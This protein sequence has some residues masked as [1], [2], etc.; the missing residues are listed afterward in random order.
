MSSHQPLSFPEPRPRQLSADEFVATFGGI[1]EHSPWVAVRTWQSGLAANADSLDGLA[2]CLAATVAAAEKD[3]Q[4]T[5][6]RAHPDLAGKAAVQG[7][8]T[9]ESTGEQSSAGLD[10]CTAD[11]FARFQALNEAYKSR[12]EF[13]FIMAVRGSDRFAILAAFEKRLHHSPDVEFS[14]ALTEIDKI[15][16]LRLRALIVAAT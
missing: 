10:Q 6:I 14:T 13:P 2:A 5:L 11:E 15:A 7:S 4:L 8:L 12:F 3:E 9:A 16:W 1:Y